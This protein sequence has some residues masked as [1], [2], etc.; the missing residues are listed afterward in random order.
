MHLYVHQVAILT[1]L[2]VPE[3]AACCRNIMAPVRWEGLPSVQSKRDSYPAR[4]RPAW[5]TVLYHFVVTTPK[6]GLFLVEEPRFLFEHKQ[7]DGVF[8]MNLKGECNQ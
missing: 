8:L 7:I 5:P 4:P 2:G 1:M 6:W 3:V